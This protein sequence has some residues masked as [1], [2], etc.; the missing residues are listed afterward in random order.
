MPLCEI[1]LCITATQELLHLARNIT[2]HV[3]AGCCLVIYVQ[4]SIH[5]GVSVHVHIISCYRYGYIKV[6]KT[7][8]AFHARTVWYASQ[9]N[10]SVPV[11]ILPS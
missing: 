10:C 8:E 9:I 5:Q 6:Q 11:C 1:L 4:I 7:I 2:S 3:V